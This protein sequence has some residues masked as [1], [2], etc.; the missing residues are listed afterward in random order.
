MEEQEEEGERRK[1]EPSSWDWI[2][3]GSKKASGR[4]I[5][6]NNV[7]FISDYLTTTIGKKLKD[8][9]L[10]TQKIHFS[11]IGVSSFP[12]RYFVVGYLMQVGR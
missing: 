10:C 8:S 11:S 7:C 2:K 4:M 5:K 3:G 12:S 6:T 1:G 9:R